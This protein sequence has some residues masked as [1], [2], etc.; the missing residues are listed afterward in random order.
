MRRRLAGR[1]GGRG[2]GPDNAPAC[3]F[4]RRAGD[5]H[6]INFGETGGGDAPCGLARFGGRV[7]TAPA[8]RAAA[9]TVSS[10]MVVV[11]NVPL[12]STCVRWRMLGCHRRG[13]DNLGTGAQGLEVRAAAA[14]AQAERSGMISG[15]SA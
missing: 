3:R 14:P 8:T 10:T 5:A 9:D 13:V 15:P 2:V 6:G 7:G 11:A 1:G 12:T 4:P